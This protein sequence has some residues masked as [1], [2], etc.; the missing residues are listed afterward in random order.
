[1][2]VIVTKKQAGLYTII[3][4]RGERRGDIWRTPQ[5]L[6]QAYD[7]AIGVFAETR[8]L[9]EAK[10]SAVAWYSAQNDCQGCGIQW[11]EPGLCP[12]CKMQYRSYM[13]RHFATD[14]ITGGYADLLEVGDPLFA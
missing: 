6:W 5:R 12:A 8:T 7:K 2:R 4:A 1:M 9:A 10:V 11:P 13:D 14:G 3:D